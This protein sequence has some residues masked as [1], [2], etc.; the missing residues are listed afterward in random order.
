MANANI[1]LNAVDNTRAAFLSVQNRLRQ[2]ERTSAMVSKGIL[3]AG[4]GI[5]GAAGIGRLVVRQFSEIISKIESIPGIPNNVAAS[6][7]AL[8]NSLQSAKSATTGFATE[9]GAKLLAGLYETGTEIGRVLSGM[10]AIER[11]R[12]RAADEARNNEALES[13]R[14]AAFNERVKDLVAE[15]ERTKKAS[16]A[17]F[18]WRSVTDNPA[19]RAKEL[20]EE[21]RLINASLEELA[22]TT[23]ATEEEAIQKIKDGIELYKQKIQVAGELRKVEEERTKAAREAARILSE[24]FEDAIFS[25]KKLSE[26]VRQLAL[27]LV[28]MA[29]RSTITAPLGKALGGFFGGLSLFGGARAGGGPVG[30]NKSYLVGERG[31]EIF[32]PSS[33][34]NV[35]SNQKSFGSG[36]GGGSTYYID[37]RGADQTGLARLEAMIKQTQASIVPMALGAVM[38]AKA[39][40]SAYYA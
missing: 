29:F 8:R 23:S 34:G 1:N 28:K 11:A 18:V 14:I 24:G 40:G 20:H 13:A 21:V 7:L 31:P 2:M 15:L 12:D 17:A 38:N 36:N 4:F 27:D 5:V 16:E 6:V 33:A 9:W 19:Q 10:N 32:T 3:R 22:G 25:G 30:A 37:A 39:R 35:I 26:V